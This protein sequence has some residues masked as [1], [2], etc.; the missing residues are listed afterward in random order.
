MGAA[1]LPFPRSRGFARRGEP[2]APGPWIVAGSH[3]RQSNGRAL[4]AVPQAS[5]RYTCEGREA[6]GAKR[7]SIAGGWGGMRPTATD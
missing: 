1:A 7:P 5:R 2:R 4:A 3:R 6:Q